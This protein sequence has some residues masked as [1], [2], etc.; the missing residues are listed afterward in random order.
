[1]RVLAI[2]NYPET[3]LGQ[4][5]VALAEQDIKIDLLVAH[6][7]E[8]IPTL[9][10]GYAGLIVLGGEQDAL[11]DEN[12]P[13]LPA[14]CDLILKF[15]EA[16]KPILGIC[17][18]AQLIA[19]AFG[20]E[21]ILG[22]PVEFGWQTVELTQKGRE[23]PV[24][25]VLGD[26]APL[27]HWHSDTVTL[28]EGAIHLAQSDMT[29]NQAYRLG[30]TTYAIQFHFEAGLDVVRH[31]SACFAGSIRQHTPDWDAQLEQAVA[32]KGAEA[33]KAGLALA[34]AWVHLLERTRE[35]VPTPA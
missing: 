8:D 11:D 13:F 18:G 26:G 24:L 16:G 22:R 5:A 12:H 1:M 17:L 23:D 3:P 35:E 34:R 25:A 19:R 20:G 33:E 28:P 30:E 31:W 4:M 7:G 14:V 29:P 21:N 15:H 32:T 10:D 9:S 6:S 2:E 27:F